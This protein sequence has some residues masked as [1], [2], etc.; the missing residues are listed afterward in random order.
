LA[1]PGDPATFQYA[2][3][4]LCGSATEGGTDGSGVQ[5]VTRGVYF[6][7]INV[8]NPSSLAVTFSWHVVVETRLGLA[9][10][11]PQISASRSVAIN[12]TGAAKIDAVDLFSLITGS[13]DVII[14]GSALVVGYAVI[15]SPIELDVTVLYTSRPQQGDVT[16]I[17]VKTVH[18]RT[19]TIARSAESRDV[20]R[21]QSS[22]VGALQHK[23]AQAFG[24]LASALEARSARAASR[25]FFGGG[26]GGGGGGG[27]DFG[28]P[29][30]PVPEPIPPEPTEPAPSPVPEPIPPEPTEPA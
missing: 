4:F 30:S 14:G 27:R 17:D 2:V 18:P 11:P 22:V 13:S 29:G 16:S 21:V 5:Q 25:G 19:V 28:G 20:R 23:L 9:V 24:R 6:T 12:S 15:V 10:N 1:R 26:R 8:H 7:L 3:K